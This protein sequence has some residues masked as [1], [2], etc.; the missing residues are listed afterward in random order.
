MSELGIEYATVRELKEEIAS[1]FRECLII[2]DDQK[3][4]D[5][6]NVFIKT[7][8]GKKGRRDKHF[9]LVVATEMLNDAQHQLTMDYLDDVEP[10]P[11]GKEG[12]EYKTEQPEVV[13]PE[14]GEEEHD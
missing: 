11:E 13:E 2:T 10:E 6:V 1:R 9:D 3:D 5:L 8:Y 14:E 4:T 7:P 12:E